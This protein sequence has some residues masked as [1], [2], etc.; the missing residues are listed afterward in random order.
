VSF[1]PPDKILVSLNPLLV[2]HF[3]PPYLHFRFIIPHDIAGGI[4]GSIILLLILLV[5]RRAYLGVSKVAYVLPPLKKQ[6][7][8]F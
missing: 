6:L 3:L 8:T 4:S 7:S 5:K 2:L 1:L